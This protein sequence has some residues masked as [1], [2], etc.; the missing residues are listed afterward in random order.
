MTDEEKNHKEAQRERMA[1][2]IVGSK[3]QSGNF[4]TKNFSKSDEYFIYEIKAK[5]LSEPIRVQIDT[6]KKTIKF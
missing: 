2:L 5:T 3:D 6:E 1:S 4:I